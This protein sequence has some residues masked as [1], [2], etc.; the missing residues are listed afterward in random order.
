M[1]DI[2]IINY[3]WGRKAYEA[4]VKDTG[5]KMSQGESW[6]KWEILDEATKA[7]WVA[8]VNAII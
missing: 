6:P 4:F 7:H 8:V 5:N 3:D 2:K 1:K